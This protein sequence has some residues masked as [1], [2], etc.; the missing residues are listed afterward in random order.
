MKI[1]IYFLTGLFSFAGASAQTLEFSQ[2]KLVTGLETVPSGTVWKVESVIYNIPVDESSYQTSQS[3][4]CGI[5]YFRS[6]AILVDG[7]P[8]KLGEGTASASYSSLSYTHTYTQLPIWLP[9]GSTL[10][11]GP[12]NNKVSVIEFTIVP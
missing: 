3:A 12:C 8:T 6:T 5:N 11:G 4:S 1:L 9:A 10:S 7:T 2:V